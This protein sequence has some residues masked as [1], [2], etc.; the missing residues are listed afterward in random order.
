MKVQVIIFLL[1]LLALSVNAQITGNV[2]TTESICISDGTVRI[3]GANPTSIYALT[4]DNGQIPQLGPFTPSMGIVIFNDLPKGPYTITEF[5]AD[6]TQPTQGVTVPGNYEQNWIFNASVDYNP[7]SGGIP[8]V[9]IT[10]FQILNAA[11]D[12]QRPPYTYRISAKNGSLP[13]LVS[14]PPAFTSVSGFSIPYPSGMNGNYEIQAKDACGNYK[15]INVYVPATAPGPGLTTSFNNFTSCTG[16]AS[17][18]ATASGGTPNYIYTIIAPSTDQVGSTQTTSG[19]ATFTLTANGTYTIQVMDQCGGVTVN[20]INVKPYVGP[21][22]SAWGA[23]GTC[24]P[25]PGLGTGG[26][27]IF[28]QADGLGPYSATITS[29]CGYGPQTVTPLTLGNATYVDGLPRPCNYTVTVM[30]GCGQTVTFNVSLVG[31]GDGI[32]GEYNYINCP[33]A[34]QTDYIQTIGV[35]FG[36]PYSPT[37]PYTFEIFD[38]SN[39]PIPGYPVTQGGGEIYPALAAGTYTYKIADACGATTVVRSITIPKYELPT[40]SVDVNNICFGAGQ[41]VLVGV[42]NNPKDPNVY[43]Y[44][45]IAGPSRVGATPETDSAP[46]TGKFSSLESGGTYTFRFNDGCKDVDITVTIPTYMQP[47]WEVAFGAIC[48]GSTTSDLEVINLQPEGMVVGPYTWRV[49]SEDSDIFNDPLPFPSAL[50]QTSTIFADLPAKNTN[51]DIATYMFQGS[52]GCKNS[53][54]G[55]GKV[56]VL[57]SQTLILDN[58][59]IC[60][61]GDAVIKA[62]VSTPLANATYIY[63][64]DNVEV[65][66]SNNLFTFIMNAMAGLYK[67]R[68]FP[69]IVN[70]PT[71]FAETPDVIVIG[72]LITECKV[73]QQPTCLLPSSGSASVTASNGLEPYMYLWSNGA[74]TSSISGLTA[75][76]YTVT[77]CDENACMIT[78]EAVLTLPNSPSVT[79]QAVQPSCASPNGGSVTANVTGGTAPLTYLWSN[80]ATTNAITGL[81]GGTFTVTVTDVNNCYSTC[82]SVITPA[83]NC[84]NINAITI[85]NIDCID[86][87]TPALITDNRIRLSAMV[88]NTNGLLTGYNVTIN[89]GTTITPNTNVPYGVTQFTLGAGTAGGGATFTITVTDSATPGCT[90]TFQ[91]VDPGTCEP[92]MPECPPVQCGTAT[93]QVNGN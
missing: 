90:Q 64:K 73:D 26:I 74:T 46:N 87:G 19:S 11:P 57:P 69:D 67:A 13:V 60:D 93:I 88:T 47:T 31:P 6:N 15:T 2:S 3:T 36:P 78:C 23:G 77:V 70:D 40:V 21:T 82:T 28:V 24:S 55:S 8:T 66:R 49:V 68:V 9:D 48:P 17:Y 38:A 52:D 32:M 81:M 43:N 30:D 27:G 5:K 80:G 14:D 12:Q 4:G 37:G 35:G 25:P 41:A 7:C 71:C 63:Y 51:L 65:A 86:N 83:T 45:I 56:G 29:D 61:N 34:G 20:T 76:T 1:S 62:R 91:V 53:F 16:D 89:G 50:G 10:N 85:Q 18:T 22:A 84:C 92:A 39:N 33:A 75:G 54:L 42:N 59:T 44:S 58:T 79:C 72:S